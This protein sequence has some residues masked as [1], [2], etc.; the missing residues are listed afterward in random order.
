[1]I[2]FAPDFRW[3]LDSEVIPW[4]TTMR[5]FRQPTTDDWKSVI[6]RIKDELMKLATSSHSASPG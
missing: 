2:P 4:Y 1:M 6:A 5:L 3:M